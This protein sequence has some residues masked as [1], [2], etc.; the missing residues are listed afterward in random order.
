MR[1]AAQELRGD[2][3]YD[4]DT[5][6]RRAWHRAGH[7]WKSNRT[8]PIEFDREA[9]KQRNLIERVNAVNQR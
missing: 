3:G 1:S 4:A 7:P 2:N 8:E 9:Y 6:M 5:L